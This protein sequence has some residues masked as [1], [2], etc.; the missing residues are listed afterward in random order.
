MYGYISV[1]NYMFYYFFPAQGFFILAYAVLLNIYIYLLFKTVRD[2][3]LEIIIYTILCKAI[4][5][6]L[7]LLTCYFLVYYLGM[8]F[9]YY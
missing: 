3:S 8:V 9:L 1:Y 6:C 2:I 7:F 5:Y 4:L